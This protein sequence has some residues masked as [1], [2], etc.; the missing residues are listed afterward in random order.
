MIK[1]YSSKK[2]DQKEVMSYYEKSRNFY[3]GMQDAFESNNWDLVGLTGIHCM[4][5]LSDAFVYP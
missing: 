5:S 2:I 4:I 1:K 3:T